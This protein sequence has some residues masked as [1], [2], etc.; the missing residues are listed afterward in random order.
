MEEE[1]KV[2]SSEQ[3]FFVHHRIESAVKTAEFIGDK[4][5]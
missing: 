5:A 4:L 3:D 2:I 1:T